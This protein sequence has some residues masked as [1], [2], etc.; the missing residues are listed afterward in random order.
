[1]IKINYLNSSNKNL[2]NNVIFID[3][4][5]DYKKLNHKYSF[6]KKLI[7]NDV[8]SKKISKQNIFVYPQK[9]GEYGIL[10][11]LENNLLNSDIENLGANF[12]NFLK[13]QNIQNIVL[14]LDKQNFVIK[15]RFINFFK[16]FDLI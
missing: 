16:S 9:N 15:N 1:M 5:T 3:S 12:Y 11:Y 2:G 6:S 7:L 14:N 8:K 4:N 13:I 10:I